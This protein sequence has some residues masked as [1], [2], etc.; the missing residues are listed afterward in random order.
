M[1]KISKTTIVPMLDI[2]ERFNT[3]ENVS[4]ELSN[5]LDFE[6]YQIE[7]ERYQNHNE[8][9]F[10][11]TKEEY[12]DYF[13][14]IRSIDVDTISS[15]ALKYR[16][17]DL[18][19]IIDHVDYYR[20]VYNDIKDFNEKD[21]IE[22]LK[23]TKFGLPDEIE[24]ND[25][26]IIFSIGLGVSGGWIYNNYTHYD[27]KVVIDK[28]TQLGLSSTIAHECHHMGINKYMKEIDENKLS[29]SMDTALVLYLC[30]EGTAI[31]YCN[32]FEGKL[33]KKIYENDEMNID[34][35]SYEYYCSN[36][37]EIYKGFKSDIITLRSGNIKDMKELEEL[38]MK[39]YFYRDVEINGELKEN[40][41][42]QPIAYH[43]GADIWGLMHDIFGRER[44]FEL[45]RDPSSFFEYYNKAL[46]KI[47]RTDLCI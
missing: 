40:Y 11:F 44:V 24:L 38:F 18:L 28:K 29:K 9:E 45:L 3:G 46:M 7:L 31:K 39:N 15:K 16:V 26:R 34:R 33:T 27:L 35:I 30:G 32:N 14:N 6:D 37:D 19:Y 17:N 23:K 41:L 36:F 1:I 25:I 22:A 13:M 43:F 47:D 8:K 4:E 42:D 12:I 2:M 5:L 10:A 20:D 21:V